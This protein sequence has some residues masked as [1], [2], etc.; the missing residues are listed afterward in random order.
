M[1]YRDECACGWP[2]PLPPPKE[3]IRRTRAIFNHK[4]IREKCPNCHRVILAEWC[5]CGYVKPRP[6]VDPAE[7]YTLD[8]SARESYETKGRGALAAA[9]EQLKRGSSNVDR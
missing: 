2:V 9:R 6:A 3:K 1:V 4:P 7:V 8:P 5:R